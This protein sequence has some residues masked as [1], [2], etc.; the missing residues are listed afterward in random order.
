MSRPTSTTVTPICTEAYGIWASVLCIRDLIQTKQ[1]TVSRWVLVLSSSI[2]CRAEYCCAISVRPSNT[3]IASEPVH[4]FRIPAGAS[5]WFMSVTVLTKF[6]CERTQ[7][8][9]ARDRKNWQFQTEV[10]VYLGNST[11]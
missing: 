7:G 8:L 1:Q 2:A 5:L 6:Q 9:N 4:T 3:D 11:R 10:A